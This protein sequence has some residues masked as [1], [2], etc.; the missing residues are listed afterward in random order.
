MFAAGDIAPGM[1]SVAN[2]IS[3]GSRA[4]AAIV[5]SLIM[6]EFGA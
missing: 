2:S 1:P 3:S 4:A 5:G 6:E